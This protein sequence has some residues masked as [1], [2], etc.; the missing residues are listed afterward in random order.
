[1]RRAIPIAFLAVSACST[2]SAG[3]AALINAG[4]GAA[5]AGASRASGGCY[6]ACPTGTSCNPTTGLCDALPCHG[7]CS[8]NEHCD[9]TGLFDRC[10]SGREGGPDIEIGKNPAE[11]RTTT[12]EAGK[13]TPGGK[14]STPP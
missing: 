10:V 1:M 14:T 3:T 9:N 6:A 2:P 5:A 13:D 12:P 8:E 7:R 11:P 4:I